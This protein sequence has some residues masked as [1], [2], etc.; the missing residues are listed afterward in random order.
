MSGDLE[1]ANLTRGNSEL[2]ALPYSRRIM[3]SRHLRFAE[4]RPAN[5]RANLASLSPGVSRH[6]RT[7]AGRRAGAEGGR[8]RFA[9]PNPPFNPAI[10]RILGTA[11]LVIPRRARETRPQDLRE[12]R[13]HTRLKRSAALGRSFRSGLRRAE[14]P[15]ATRANTKPRPPE[16]DSRRGSGIEIHYLRIH[17]FRSAL[18]TK[19]R[20]GCVMANPAADARAPEQ[21]LHRHLIESRS[22]DVMVALTEPSAPR[23]KVLLE[24]ERPSR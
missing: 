9:Q 23:N 12:T 14:S 21:D 17:L 6:P 11:M 19:G 4:V 1:S 20:T 8:V 7:S 2:N 15:S 24:R 5:R 16:G 13:D 18:D 22:V 3:G 10:S